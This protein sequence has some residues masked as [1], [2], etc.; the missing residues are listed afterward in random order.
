M[1][2]KNK[3]AARHAKRPRKGYVDA[4]AALYAP[5]KKREPK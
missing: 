3:H 5:V 1:K 2:R 4:L